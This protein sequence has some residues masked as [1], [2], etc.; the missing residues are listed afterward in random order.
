MSVRQQFCGFLYNY[1]I[2]GVILIF[3]NYFTIHSTAFKPYVFI[4]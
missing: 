1:V 4:L 2:Y 3:I